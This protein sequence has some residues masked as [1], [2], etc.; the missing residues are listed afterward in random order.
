[1]AA[2]KRGDKKR[3][4]RATAPAKATT[5][6]RKM[7][8]AKPSR[9]T[10]AAA[11]RAKT[12]PAGK[13]AARSATPAKPAPRGSTGRAV[14]RA[15]EASTEWPYL[16]VGHGR[17]DPPYPRPSLSPAPTSEPLRPDPLYIERIVYEGVSRTLGGAFW[18]RPDPACNAIVEGVIGKALTLYPDVRM[19]AFTALS[20]HLHYMLSATMPEQIPLFLDYMLGNIARQLNKLR[21]RSGVFWSRR[22]SIVPIVDEA[23]QIERLAYILGQGP[24]AGLVASRSPIGCDPRSGPRSAEPLRP[25]PPPFRTAATL[26]PAGLI[27]HVLPPMGA[28]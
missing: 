24:A 18:L 26:I 13:V 5:S 28:R 7:A 1:M 17:P 25:Y 16:H 9:R 4:S 14:V 19:H 8:T 12:K 15:P 20:N 2:A 21:G 11:R 22:T 27:S 10:G 3:K 6:A 23:K